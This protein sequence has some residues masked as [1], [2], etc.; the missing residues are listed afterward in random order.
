MS[1]FW[2]FDEFHCEFQFHSIDLYCVLFEEALSL[3]QS[4][5]TIIAAVGVMRERWFSQWPKLSLKVLL[6]SLLSNCRYLWKVFSSPPSHWLVSP[7]RQSDNKNWHPHKSPELVNWHWKSF[8]L[9]LLQSLL[10]LS[11]PPLSLWPFFRLWMPHLI[12]PM[13]VYGL[14][15]YKLSFPPTLFTEDVKEQEKDVLCLVCMVPHSFANGCGLERLVQELWQF[16]ERTYPQ[17]R[18]P[19]NKQLQRD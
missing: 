5:S 1:Q 10:Y 17:R 12:W 9:N 4:L 6:A 11:L 8:I 14:R 16:S 7:H 19:T 2:Y 3:S 15:K 18:D 13:F